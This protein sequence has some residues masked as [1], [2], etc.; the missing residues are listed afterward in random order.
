MVALVILIVVG[1]LIFIAFG[2]DLSGYMPRKGVVPERPEGYVYRSG[3]QIDSNGI[4]ITTGF[5]YAPGYTSIK[6]QCTA[7]HSPKLITQ[8][9]ATREGWQQIIRWM[10][11]TQ[12]LWDLGSDE[13]VILD[14]L[15]EHYAPEARGRRANLEPD[16]IDWY[17]LK[18][19]QE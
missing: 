9:R 14:Y 5:V 17:V 8:V 11:Q 16:Q 4:D 7:C 6:R 1:A 18:T 13:P 19:D 2:D 15:A 10:Q 12:G 3:P